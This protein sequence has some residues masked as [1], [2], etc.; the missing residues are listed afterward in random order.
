[1]TPLLTEYAALLA[2]YDAVISNRQTYGLWP[3]LALAM[4]MLVERMSETERK[5]ASTLQ[6]QLYARRIA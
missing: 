4:G 5:Q 2:A 3:L 1:M 6:W